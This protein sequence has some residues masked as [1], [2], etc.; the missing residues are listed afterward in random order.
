MLLRRKSRVPTLDLPRQMYE[1]A[2]LVFVNV[3]V[4]DAHLA[5]HYGL[6]FENCAN[7]TRKPIPFID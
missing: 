6:E 1:F 5:S 4:P 2:G 3:P 7:R